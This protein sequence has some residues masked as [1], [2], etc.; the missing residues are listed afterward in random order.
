MFAPLTGAVL[1]CPGMR[2][3]IRQGRAPLEPARPGDSRLCHNITTATQPHLAAT[4]NVAVAADRRGSKSS[5]GADKGGGRNGGGGRGGSGGG[6]GGRGGAADVDA[7]TRQLQSAAR[8][9]SARAQVV[10]SGRVA[11]QE[12]LAAQDAL[13]GDGWRGGDPEQW[14]DRGDTSQRRQQQQQQQQQGKGGRRKQKGGQDGEDE[15]DELWPSREAVAGPPPAAAAAAAEAPASDAGAIAAASRAGSSKAAGAV[16]G[17]SKPSDTAGLVAALRAAAAADRQTRMM[18]GVGAATGAGAGSFFGGLRR[19]AAGGGSGSSSIGRGEAGSSSAD[20]AEA[21]GDEGSLVP[22]VDVVLQEMGLPPRAARRGTPGRGGP[23]NPLPATAPGSGSESDEGE[24]PSS[25]SSKV[26]TRGRGAKRG[27]LRALLGSYTSV[28]CRALDLELQ[29][30]WQ[31]SEERL[32][33]WKRSRLEAEG[34]ALF[35]LTAA[36]D[37]T[38]FRD[39]VLRFYVPGRPLPFHCLGAGDIVLVSPNNKPG[40]SSLEGVV[41]DFSTRWMRVALPADLAA[42]V[43]G[44]GWRLDLYANTI[45]HERARGAVKR[46]TQAAAESGSS[47]EKDKDKDRDRSSS[48]SS[49]SKGGEGGS[50]SGGGGGG[51]SVVALLRALAGS[52]PA[53]SSLEEVAAAAPP[54]LRGKAGRERLTSARRVLAAASAPAAAAA[55]AA[56]EEEASGAAGGGAAGQRARGGGGGGAGLNPSQARA[57]ETALTRSLTLWQGPPG[58]GKT[59]TLLRFI[60]AALA[61]LPGSGSGYGP[62]LATA[63]SNVAVDNLVSGLR[64]LD[65]GLDVVRVGQPAK[66]AP[67]LRGVSLEARIAGTGAGQRAARLRKQAQGLRGSEAWKY[68]SQALELEEAAA[69]DI[70]SRA[71]VV[72]ATCIGAGE[73]RLQTL[74]FPVVVL[75]EATQATEPHSLVPLLNQA[76]QVVLVGDPRQLPPTVKSR[77]AEALGLGL[78]LFERLQLMGL[79]PLL[80]DTQYR[81]HPSIA[82]WPSAAFYQGKLV[83]APKPSER[84]PPTGFPWPNPKVPVC[85][86]PVRGRE[87]RTAAANDVA[88]PG[89]AAGY[90]YQNDDE[91]AVVAAAV[92]ALLTPGAAA[93]LEGGVGDIGIITPYNG[94]VR[95]LQQLLRGGSRLSRGLGLGSRPGAFLRAAPSLDE[96]GGGGGGGGRVEP[97]LEVKSVDGFQGRE[98]EVI[99]FSAV[100]SNPEGR[101]GFVSDPRRLNVAITR[102]KRGLVVVGNPDTL[103][104]DRLWAR[105]LRWVEGQ[106]CVLEGGLAPGAGAGAG[107]GGGGGGGRGV[108]KKG[109]A[110]ELESEEEGAEDVEVVV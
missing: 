23:Q 36:P 87:S 61:A 68:I 65:P 33:T 69:R 19:L 59:A 89:G 101:L 95:C 90:S 9:A 96:D 109:R 52:V 86:I 5:G 16:T 11:L 39:A 55:V 78:P 8:R 73:A 77:E 104:N 75:D 42:G 107:G 88:T 40:E 106:G 28:W 21:E 84:R 15:E 53:G 24:E 74:S 45:A 80:L 30:E 97:V 85:F 17:S 14:P 35:D 110:A 49:S 51:E 92:A 67:E 18:S 99:V 10:G 27:A 26:K 94:Q 100:R 29:E 60:R 102:A 12:R 20:G 76:Q 1:G 63:A 62:L 105:W 46:Y 79:Q 66:V 58:T 43:Q 57:V 91:A 32:K 103:M 6:R 13:D 22:Y 108:G 2:P 71:Q 4:R 64:I 98:K 93:G 70:L 44:S 31:E 50:S 56:G 25:S 3:G 34:A 83:S 47:S 72:A 41:L 38:L 81:M 7:R 54:W 48:S 37:H 82:A